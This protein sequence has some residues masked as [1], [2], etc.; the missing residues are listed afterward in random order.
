MPLKNQ[1]WSIAGALV[2]VDTLSGK[3]AKEMSEAEH[4]ACLIAGGY[5]LRTA[6]QALREEKSR[7]LYDLLKDGYAA[8]YKFDTGLLTVTL[9]RGDR[10]TETLTFN[11]GAGNV[12]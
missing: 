7:Q 10:L 2:F 12:S 9:K 1:P 3:T 4:A 8:T 5:N 6:V 11:L